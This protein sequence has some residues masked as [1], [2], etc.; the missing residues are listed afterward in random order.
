M[1]TPFALEEYGFKKPH[2]DATSNDEHVRFAYPFGEASVT[3][4]VS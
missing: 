1:V 3:S 2:P 4:S